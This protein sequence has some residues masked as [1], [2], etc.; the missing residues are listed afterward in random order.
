MTRTGLAGWLEAHALVPHA[1]E[2]DLIDPPPQR[3]PFRI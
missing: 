1:A 2:H 3:F